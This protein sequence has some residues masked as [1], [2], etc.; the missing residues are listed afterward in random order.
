MIRRII[1]KQRTRA[2]AGSRKRRRYTLERLI[3]A[4]TEENRHGVVDWG[5]PVGNEIWWSRRRRCYQN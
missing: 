2:K 4:I 1:P 3:G 5:Q